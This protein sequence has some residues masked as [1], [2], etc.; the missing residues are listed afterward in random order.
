MAFSLYK[1][2]K[3]QVSNSKAAGR[4]NREI[5]ANPE[6]GCSFLKNLCA[7]NSH[8]GCSALSRTVT[9]VAPLSG[10]VIKTVLRENHQIALFSASFVPA[11]PS[12]IQCNFRPVM[13]RKGLR[14]L[15]KG[16]KTN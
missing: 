11:G 16:L 8:S 5:R 6:I 10:T 9:R 13:T 15:D 2:A 1:V 4:E 3:S 12:P 14:R 7:W